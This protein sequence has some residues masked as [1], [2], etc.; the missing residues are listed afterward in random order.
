MTTSNSPDGSQARAIIIAAVIGVVG[1]IIA[2]LI[3]GREWGERRAEHD[4]GG[5]ET[6]LEQQEKAFQSLQAELSAR[7]ATIRQGEQRAQRAEEQL[8]QATRELT[9]V[10]A[11]FPERTT[12]SGPSPILQPTTASMPQVALEGPV[13]VERVAPFQILLQLCER[14]GGGVSCDLQIENTGS[15]P[16]YL[17]LGSTSTAL[18]VAG[19]ECRLR[20][21]SL[22]SRRWNADQFGAIRLESKIP[23]IAKLQFEQVPEGVASGA[24]RLVIAV[25]PGTGP[26]AFFGPNPEWQTPTFKDIPFR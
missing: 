26:Q 3:G 9:Q 16:A 6:R 8:A 4:A 1:A 10:R 19:S 11:S 14:I 15:R 21:A 24:L 25:V 20:G 5:L 7:D 2:A 13:A 12:S 23:L 22:G 18:F 17:A